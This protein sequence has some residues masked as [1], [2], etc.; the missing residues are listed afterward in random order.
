MAEK[1]PILFRAPS[2]W[3]SVKAGR[4]S[5]VPRPPGGPRR[6]TRILLGSVVPGG[7]GSTLTDGCGE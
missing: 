5:R 1:A 4:G 6:E 2:C 3:I 7:A